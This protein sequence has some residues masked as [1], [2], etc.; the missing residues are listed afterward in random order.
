M[1]G[2]SG[3]IHGEGVNLPDALRVD[4]HDPSEV[5]VESRVNRRVSGC[6]WRY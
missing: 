3:T 6:R 5:I 1:L 2:E 4:R